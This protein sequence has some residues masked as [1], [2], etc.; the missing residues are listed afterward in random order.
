MRAVAR[1]LHDEPVV[2]GGEAGLLENRRPRERAMI[3]IAITEIALA[4]AKA[5]AAPIQ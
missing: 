1:A 3:L 5:P 4:D 2:P